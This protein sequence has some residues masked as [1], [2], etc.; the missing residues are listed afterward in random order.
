MFYVHLFNYEGLRNQRDFK[1]EAGQTKAGTSF[2]Q[3]KPQDLLELLRSFN[4]NLRTQTARGSAQT[5][6][7]LIVT[8]LWRRINIVLN[9][10]LKMQ[11]LRICGTMKAF[12]RNDD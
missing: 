3:L 4:I 10:T 1:R 6:R 7:P 12:Q 8:N 9:W 11:N 2:S 5:L